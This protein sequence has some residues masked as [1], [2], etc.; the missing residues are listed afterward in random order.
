[1]GEESGQKTEKD[2]PAF[3]AKNPKEWRKYFKK[4]WW[5]IESGDYLLVVTADVDEIKNTGIVLTGVSY[6]GWR[7]C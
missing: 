5:L 1:M 7:D 6:R 3:S 2:K 4:A